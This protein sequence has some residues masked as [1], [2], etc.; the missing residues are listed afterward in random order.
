MT[1]TF[2]RIR[3]RDLTTSLTELVGGGLVAYATWQVFHP[4]GIALLGLELIGIGYVL[5]KPK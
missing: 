2:R 1:S 3:F 4:A 5:S